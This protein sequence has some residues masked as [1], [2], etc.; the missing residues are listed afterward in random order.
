MINTTQT[1]YNDNGKKSDYQDEI[2]WGSIETMI[3]H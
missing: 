3:F 1:R 2:S